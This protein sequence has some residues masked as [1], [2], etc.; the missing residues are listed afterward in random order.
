MNEPVF[1]NFI[2]FNCLLTLWVCHLLSQTDPWSDGLTQLLKNMLWLIGS[3]RAINVVGACG[4]FLVVNHSYRS[5]PSSSLSFPLYIHASLLFIFTFHNE[6][7]TR[8]LPSYLSNK[9]TIYLVQ[10]S[11]TPL[12]PSPHCSSGKYPLP[13]VEFLYHLFKFCISIIYLD[14]SDS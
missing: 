2:L 12:L 8:A 3:P 11:T 1:S 5:V 10:P 6:F 13:H 9:H 14:P 4:T 7:T